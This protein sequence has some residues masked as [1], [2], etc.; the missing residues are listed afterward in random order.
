MTHIAP[1]CYTCKKSVPKVP[2][3][4]PH[5]ADAGGYA[6]CIEWPAHDGGGPTPDVLAKLKSGP[7][8]GS[9]TNSFPGLE[10]L[11]AEGDIRVIQVRSPFHEAVD[12]DFH[13]LFRP[14]LSHFNG[15][16]DHPEEIARSG[17]V[18][19]ETLEVLHEDEYF[20]VLEVGIKTSRLLTRESPPD[21]QAPVKLSDVMEYQDVEWSLL[22][23]GDFR[24]LDFNAQGDLGQWILLQAFGDAYHLAATGSTG[25]HEDRFF[26]SERTIGREEADRLFDEIKKN[27]AK[28]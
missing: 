6:E 28:T 16:E 27:E 8:V 23:H 2:L 24:L 18:H 1:T 7:L 3:T 25:F 4:L 22:T 14:A 12:G 10:H 21:S 15:W 20:A 17:R 11:P 26:T 9:P 13:V 5:W 19:C